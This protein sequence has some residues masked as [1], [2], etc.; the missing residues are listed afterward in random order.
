MLERAQRRILVA[1]AARKA[2]RVVAP[3]PLLYARDGNLYGRARGDDYRRVDDA[4]LLRADEQ[5][6]VNDN[7]VAV[8][9]VVDEEVW[10]AS[11]FGNFSHL[12]ESTRERLLEFEEGE[13]A[14]LPYED[15]RYLELPDRD[16]LARV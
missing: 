13:R 16:G 5:L 6:A 14:I 7:H 2:A 10:D 9:L 11:A 1:A 12:Y 15:G 3:A 4:V 8:G